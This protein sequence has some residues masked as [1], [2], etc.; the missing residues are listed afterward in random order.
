MDEFEDLKLHLE[1]M[2]L[3]LQRSALIDTQTLFQIMIEKEICSIDEITEARSQVEENNKDV[4][5]IDT[6]IE[7]LTGQRPKKYTQPIKSEL[8]DE[9]KSLLN[10]LGNSS[11]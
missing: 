2:M 9:L 4:Q 5:R 10:Q 11:P 1:T 7:K 8:L 3:Q 6:E